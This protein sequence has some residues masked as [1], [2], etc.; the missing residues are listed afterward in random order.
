MGTTHAEI[1]D[2]ILAGMAEQAA[3]AGVSNVSI[4]GVSVQRNGEE[5]RRQFLFHLRLAGGNAA[6]PRCAQIDLSGS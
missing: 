6:R 4:D 1:A 5:Q 2:Q 3:A